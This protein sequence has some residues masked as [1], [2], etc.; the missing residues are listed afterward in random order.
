MLWVLIRIASNEYP[1][2]RFLLRTGKNYL[3]IITKYPPYVFY[4]PPVSTLRM[5]SFLFNNYYWIKRI[6]GNLLFPPCLRH[7]MS[8]ALISNYATFLHLTKV[9]TVHPTFWQLVRKIKTRNQC[10]F[11]L[12]RRRILAKVSLSNFTSTGCLILEITESE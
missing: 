11:I 4:W 7:I 2:H 9:I 1:Q 12:Y 5:I 6:N 10:C 8:A 3:W